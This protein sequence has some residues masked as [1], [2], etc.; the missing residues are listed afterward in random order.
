[1]KLTI[2][3][4]LSMGLASAALAD[5]KQSDKKP[6]AA[7]AQQI[8]IPADAVEVGPNAYRYTDPA[9]KSW[10]YRKTPFGVT[11]AEEKPASPDAAKKVQTEKDRL[12]DATSAREDGDSIRFDRDSPFGH[13]NWRRKKTE[14]NEVEQAVW[15]RELRNRA[16]RESASSDNVAKD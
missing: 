2:L 10:L 16:A 14:L 15:N 7:K 9:G 1:M 3:A 6:A 5:D 13:M 12:I 11:R 4:L 8:A